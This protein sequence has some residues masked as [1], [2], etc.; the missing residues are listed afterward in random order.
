VPNVAS[1]YC[2]ITDLRKGDLRL[3]PYMGD[4]TSYVSGAAEEIDAALGHLYETPIDV[5]NTSEMTRP[6]ILFLKKINW[7][8][9]SG[10]LVLDLAASSESLE[11]H[12]Y[13][14]R[15]LDE[16]LLMLERLASGDLKLDGAEPAG[17]IDPET[18]NVS[19]PQI[20]NEDSESLVQAFYDQMNPRLPLRFTPP[21][22]YENTR[23]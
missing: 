8:L 11:L 14:K 3:P 20:I 10:R 23:A 13:G 7:L 5:G 9:A 19:G 17:D 1:A 15:M 6:S 16:G 12:A 21:S 22:P 4:G 18:I 2:A